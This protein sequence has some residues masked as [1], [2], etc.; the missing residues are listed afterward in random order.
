MLRT[1]GTLVFVEHQVNYV[2]L[3]SA[4]ADPSHVSIQHQGIC[5]PIVKLPKG[6]NTRA[7]TVHHLIYCESRLKEKELE[8]LPNAA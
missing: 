7:S 8:R 2:W 6:G 4:T 1:L 3:P 5:A